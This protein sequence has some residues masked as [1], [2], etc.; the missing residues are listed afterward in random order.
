[1]KASRKYWTKRGVPNLKCTSLFGHIENPFRPR[2]G[3]MMDVKY[4]YDGLKRRGK[5]HGG[6]YFFT[7]PIYLPV[8]SDL[9]KAILTKDFPHFLGHGL[10]FD[11]SIDPL[12]AHLFHLE[13]EKWRKM[14]Q[15]LSPTFTSGKLKTMFN[16][17][18]DCGLPMINHLH[19]LCEKGEAVDIKETLACYATDVIGS[20]AFGLECNSFKDP[21]A[22]FRK[23]G[24][25]IFESSFKNLVHQFVAFWSPGLLKRLKLKVMPAEIDDFFI[26]TVENIINYR[27]RNRIMRNDFMQLFLEMREHA[28]TKDEEPLTINE[29]AAQAFIFFVA[30]FETSSTTMTFCLHELAFHQQIQ[31]TLRME[32]RETLKKTGGS[33][34]YDAV[35]EMKYLDKIINGKFWLRTGYNIISVST[36]IIILQ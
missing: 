36:Y 10:E 5:K 22:E 32:I 17:L 12:S 23:Y 19:E 6:M 21:D 3:L 31:D 1:M 30:G 11:S 2:R 13:G 7:D 35:M 18:L 25:K 15:M 20:C 24:R 16:T 28:A 34:T 29:I 14:R 9:I 33:L 26:N 27:T 4:C 8:D